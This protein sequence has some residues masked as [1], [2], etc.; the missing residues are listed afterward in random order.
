[1]LGE[2]SVRRVGRFR[3]PVHELVQDDQ[4]VA[5]MGR[6]GWVK[7]FI[8]RG[9]RVELA[10]G[11]KWRVKAIGSAGT[12]NPAVFDDQGRRIAISAIGV[13]GYGINGKSYGCLLYRAEKRRFARANRWLLREHEDELAIVTRHPPG[14]EAALPVHLGAIV[15]SF[16]LIRYGI[17]G[18]RAPRLKL[19]WN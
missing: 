5:S 10:D 12:I 4:V 14:V 16:T 2:A 18:E 15:L 11:S 3:F 1:M 19:R 17:L 7:V 8:G 6:T 13:G 9:Q